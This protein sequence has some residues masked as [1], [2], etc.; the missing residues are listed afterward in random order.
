MGIRVNNMTNVSKQSAF[1]DQPSSPELVEWVNGGIIR[2][3]IIII[4]AAP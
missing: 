1:Y 2:I 3:A 4:G